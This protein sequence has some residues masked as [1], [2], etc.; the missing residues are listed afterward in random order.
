M[1]RYQL[2]APPKHDVKVRRVWVP[3]AVLM[4]HVALRVRHLIR[5]IAM[6]HEVAILSGKVASEYIHVL[7]AY[8]PL[9]ISARLCSG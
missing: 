1:K 4:G 2:G 9:W 5:Q 8:R 6:E 3:K 7:V